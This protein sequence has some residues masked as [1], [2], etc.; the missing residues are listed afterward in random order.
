MTEETAKRTTG[1]Q[2]LS[3][4]ATGAGPFFRLPWLSTGN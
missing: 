2:M 3:L 4:P 1:I